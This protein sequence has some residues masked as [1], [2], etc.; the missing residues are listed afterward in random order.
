MILRI[1]CAKSKARSDGT[2]YGLLVGLTE[3]VA[4]AEERSPGATLKAL[5]NGCTSATL[6]VLLPRI[7]R[8]RIVPPDLGSLALNFRHV[9]AQIAFPL[10]SEILESRAPSREPKLRLRL[11]AFILRP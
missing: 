3:T 1:Y 9:D 10:C 4:L 8:T 11:A 5:V 7:T 6:V 2:D